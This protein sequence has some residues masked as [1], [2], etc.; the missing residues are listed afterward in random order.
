MDQV[1]P[2]TPASSTPTNT[3]YVGSLKPKRRIN[4]FVAIG[5]VVL[6]A[7]SYMAY[8]ALFAAPTS[9]TGGSSDYA[10]GVNPYNCTR[11]G[12]TPLLNTDS[13]DDDDCI[14]RLKWWMVMFKHPGTLNNAESGSF[15]G[16]YNQ[17]L[18]DAVKQFKQAHSDELPNTEGENFGQN[19]WA[20][21][22]RLV[23]EAP[24]VELT[25]TPVVDGETTLSW[26]TTNR[27]ACTASG[28]TWTGPIT[29]EEG[30]AKRAVEETT[31]FTLSCESNNSLRTKSDSVTVQAVTD[32]VTAEIKIV[33]GSVST[34]ATAST[35][36]T[37][38]TEKTVS[39][40]EDTPG[41]TV[42]Y[43]SSPDDAICAPADAKGGPTPISDKITA[44]GTVEFSLS[45]VKGD[46]TAAAKVIVNVTEK[47]PATPTT[48]NGGTGTDGGTT[49]GTGTTTATGDSKGGTEA[50]RTELADTGDETQIPTIL[51]ALLLLTGLGLLRR[52][53]HSS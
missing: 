6:L 22:N 53:H 38:T 20:V 52:R 15:T 44:P 45:C 32:E 39:I 49:L 37:A 19:A 28:G 11:D 36:D 50:D 8:R 1:T 12:G 9:P 3:Q 18:I 29:A 27:D 2:P 31:E 7:G 16:D 48:D 13:P 34:V 41:V 10:S 40:E 26:V 4:V 51:G 42:T 5:I 25:A 43:T 24:T 35:P 30:S 17:G 21:L 46:K 33:N 47:K 14:R 23:Q